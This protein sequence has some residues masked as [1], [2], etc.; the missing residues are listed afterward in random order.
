M[1][2]H[3]W[4]YILVSVE[5]DTQDI[6]SIK[7]TKID[8]GKGILYQFCLFWKVKSTSTCLYQQQHCLLPMQFLYINSKNSL[9]NIQN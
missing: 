5:I 7:F 3:N 8:C 9:C 2:N 1:C 6:L 4:H